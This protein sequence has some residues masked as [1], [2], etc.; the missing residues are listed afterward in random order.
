MKLERMGT[1]LKWAADNINSLIRECLEVNTKLFLIR[2]MLF[3][4]TKY[5]PS[6]SFT[7]LIG[8]KLV[9]ILHKKW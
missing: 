8:E 2:Y 7:C 3:F 9:N 1:M 5:V 4:L 6:T